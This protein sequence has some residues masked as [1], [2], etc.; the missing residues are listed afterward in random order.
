V[1]V[2]IEISSEVSEPYFVL[3]ASAM[4]KELQDAVAELEQ[5]DSAGQQDRL[6]TVFDDNMRIVVL[7]PDEVFYQNEKLSRGIQVLVHMG[8]GLTVYFAAALYLQWMPVQAGPWA[9]VAWVVAA[10][11][12]SFIIWLC[13]SLY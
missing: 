10:L 3:H 6:I 13:F 4:T 1:K 5:T 9:I 12:I 2:S 11:L 8:I 7:Q